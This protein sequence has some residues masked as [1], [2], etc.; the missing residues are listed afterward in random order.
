[1]K[2][3]TRASLALAL[4]V[5][6]ERGLAGPEL[7]IPPAE[8]RWSVS[9]GLTV[10]SLNAA[11]DFR[12]SPSLDWRNFLPAPGNGDPGLFTG[13]TTPV[14]YDNG[15]V[16]G[17]NPG[18]AGFGANGQVD[19][20]GQISAIHSG[21]NANGNI[22][23]TV[24]FQSLDYDEGNRFETSTDGSVG[25]GPSLQF[26]YRLGESL[27]TTFE[28]MTGWSFVDS[29]TASGSLEM[30]PVYQVTNIYLYDY[31]ANSAL[32]LDIPGT[33]AGTDEF[34]VYDA[35]DVP[36]FF[37][38]GFES[39]R[40]G[41][42]QRA[43]EPYAVALSS[44]ELDTRLVEIPLGLTAWR[45]LGPLQ[46]GFNGGLTLNV[47]DYDLESRFAWFQGGNDEAAAQF[48]WNQSGT[49]LKVGMFAGLSAR[50]PLSKDERLFLEASGSYRW[51]DPVHAAAGPVDVEIDA[52]SAEGRF[53]VGIVL[54]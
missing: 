24:A 51:I 8:S 4:I 47:I 12:P 6:S 33:V 39:P 40:R 34:L 14:V 11:F 28:L 52:S 17:E 3:W 9:A 1:M 43:D 50:L 22:A 45:D 16:G 31:V 21:V 53:G 42:S 54:W 13:G 44:A 38:T 15:V 5:F 20:A 30:L 36:A 7:E 18:F 32:P 27:G 25:T 10:R 23:R 29:E 35:A 19:S 2:T 49:H 46:L 37:G 26:A 41:N 48:R